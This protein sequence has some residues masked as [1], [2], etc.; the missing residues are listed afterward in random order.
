MRKLTVKLDRMSYVNEQLDQI[1]DIIT[2]LR[3]RKCAVRLKKINSEYLLNLSL[4]KHSGYKIKR[5][6]VRVPKIYINSISPA[7]STIS[8][9]S[10][11]SEDT[12]PA[13]I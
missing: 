6:R 9:I 3:I 5:L 7:L 4:S 13:N 8:N 12:A 11:V 10:S 2:D 1:Q